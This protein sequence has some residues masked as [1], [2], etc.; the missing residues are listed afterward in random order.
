MDNSE[1]YEK[2]DEN[3]ETYYAVFPTIRLEYFIDVELMRAQLDC[4]HEGKVEIY[5]EDSFIPGFFDVYFL[6]EAPPNETEFALVGYAIEQMR[7]ALARVYPGLSPS[8]NF[9]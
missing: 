3:N 8:L 2:T 5:K 4:L 9:R 1:E 7:N 6:F